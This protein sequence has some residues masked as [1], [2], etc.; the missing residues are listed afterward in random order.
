MVKIKNPLIDKL[1]GKA[2]S[3]VCFDC[4]FWHVYGDGYIEIQNKPSEYFLP[5]EVGGFQLIRKDD[6][7]DY[8]GYF[9][10]TFLPPSNEDVS[11]VSPEFA[12]VL[13]TT[14]AKMKTVQKKLSLNWNDAYKYKVHPTDFHLIDKSIALYLE[15]NHVQKNRKN[16]SW[17]VDL[18]NLCSQSVVVVKG[19]SDL[20]SIYNASKYYSFTFQIPMRIKD[21]AQWNSQSRDKCDTA[22]LEGTYNCIL[23][24]V[25]DQGTARKKLRDILP[26]GKAHDPT[27]DAAM[28][29]I[30]ALYIVQTTG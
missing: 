21:I 9:F 5:R 18:L 10:A 7:W 12:T 11:F 1:A 17:L 29:F 14:A 22:K 24:E 16:I 8:D 6:G 3:I 26:V 27:S 25:E 2:N 4:E 20:Q 28:T 13:A 23:D 30:V 19:L 15:D